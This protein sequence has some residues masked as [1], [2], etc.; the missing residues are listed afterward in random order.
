MFK[1]S[2][3]LLRL[4]ALIQSWSR[5]SLQLRREA[6]EEVGSRGRGR[7]IRSLRSA[8]ATTDTVLKQNTKIFRMP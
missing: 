1:K 5:G 4:Y 3:V 2:N 8:W 7:E 6:E